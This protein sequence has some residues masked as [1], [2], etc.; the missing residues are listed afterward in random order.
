MDIREKI[1]KEWLIW[2]GGSG[3]FLQERGLMGG[4]LPETWNLTRPQDVVDMNRAFFEAGC[5]IVNTNTFGANR[6]KYKDNLDE[7][8]SAAVKLAKQAREEAKKTR[9]A[10]KGEADKAKLSSDMYIALDI[11]PTGKLLEPMGDLAF[12]DA[13]EVFAEVVRIG[14]REGADLILIETMSDGYETKAAVLAAKENCDLPIIVT[15]VYDTAGRLLTG[16]D[17]EGVTAMLEG[18]HVDALGINCSLGPDEMYPVVKRITEA[19][20]TPVVVNPNAGLPRVEGNKTVFDIGPEE[21]AESMKKIADLGIQIAGGCCGTTP[22]HIKCLAEAIKVRPFKEQT[23]KDICRVTSFASTVDIGEKTVV[24]GERINPTGKKRFKEALRENDIPYIINEGL[25]QEEQ[26]AHI[27]D[28]NVGLPEIDEPLMMENVIKRLQE[29]TP[30]PLQIDTTDIVAL[31]RAMRIYNGK[32]MINSVNGKQEVIE[33]VMPLVAKYG[34]VLVSLVLDEDGIPESSEKRVEIAEKIYKAADSYG[35]PRSD[36]VIDGLCMTISSDTRSALATLETL[37]R[38]HDE[39]NGRTILGVSNI[40]FGLPAR[41]VVTANFLTMAM[42]EHLSCAIINPGSELMMNAYYASNALMGRDDQCMEFIGALS[43]YVPISKR[44][45]MAQQGNAAGGQPGSVDGAQGNVAGGQSGTGDGAQGS[46]N[47]AGNQQG[48]SELFIA[49]RKGLKDKAAS[50]VKAELSNRSAMEIIDKDLI[51]ALDIVGQGFE[52]GTVFLPQLLM[53]ADAAKAAFEVIKASM[54]GSS[55]NIKGRVILATV[56]G[57]IHDIGKNIVKVMLENYGYDVIDLGKDVPPELIVDTAIKEDIQLV[58]LSA[59]MTTTVV[60]MEETIK[61]LREKKPD[62]KV[63]VGGAV[64]TQE[65]SDKIGADHYAKDA[66]ATVRY[67]DSV[68]GV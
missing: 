68:F 4:E 45:A 63:V 31:E 28:V 41:E 42:R 12:E 32:P 58:G 16:A 2:D 22:E 1:G 59:L 8:V 3:T 49:V 11:G 67:A 61:L 36:I 39:Y 27:L 51:P 50:V 56:K 37:R 25:K 9:E 35:I 47:G 33:A 10:E 38:I 66:M 34:G 29:V 26:G 19:S 17:V 57:D 30:L 46:V 24:I 13:V 62:T 43:E 44:T 40:S 5:D 6:F 21:F 54:A 60:S 23:Q 15:N 65:Y 7:I 18:L 14:A 64:M 48:N 55:Q 52:K 53:S 20:S